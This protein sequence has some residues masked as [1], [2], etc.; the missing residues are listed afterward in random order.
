MDESLLITKYAEVVLHVVL[1][2]IAAPAMVP[3]L[4]RFQPYADPGLD[5]LRR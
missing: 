4:S 3:I 2:P 5:D 1:Q